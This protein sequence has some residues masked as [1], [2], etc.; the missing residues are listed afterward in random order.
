MPSCGMRRGDH[1]HYPP[2]RRRGRP[3]GCCSTVA[4]AFRITAAV[5]RGGRAPKTQRRIPPPRRPNCTLENS[6]RSDSAA[7]MPMTPTTVGIDHR[8]CEPPRPTTCR[9]NRDHPRSKLE[10]RTRASSQKRLLPRRHCRRRRGRQCRASRTDRTTPM[11]RRR[12]R[13]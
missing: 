11:T 8:H 5:R 10:E 13:H 4:P 3:V 2:H 12:G 1:S 9:T 7:A 6:D